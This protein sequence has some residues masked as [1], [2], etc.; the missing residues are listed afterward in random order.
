MRSVIALSLMSI[1]LA[2]T[3]ND[4]IVPELQRL[5]KPDEQ[6]V[7]CPNSTAAAQSHTFDGETLITVIGSDAYAHTLAQLLSR[8]LQR[9]ILIKKQ[10]DPKDPVT[11]LAI[12]AHHYLKDDADAQA[13]LNA[14]TKE[15]T[16]EPDT[17]FMTRKQR[18]H[19]RW[20]YSS[21]L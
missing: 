10:A 16:Q 12:D 3:A 2:I 7:R 19:Y 6:F 9:N 21:R 14:I 17:R 18:R 20:H 1:S 4:D 8:R 13:R 11:M 15:L 5:L